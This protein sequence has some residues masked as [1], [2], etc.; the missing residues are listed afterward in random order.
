MRTMNKEKTE[1][2]SEFLKQYARDNNGTSPGLSEIMEYMGMSKATAYRYILEL[3]RQGLVSYSGKNTLE[4]D[5]QRK[6]NCG[7]RKVPLVGQIVC[8]TPD[9]QEE[10]ISEY[11]AI[12]EEWVDGEC[13]LLRAYGD[14]MI[15]IGI[16]KDDLILVKRAE[17]AESGDVVVALTENGNTLKRLFW[18]GNKPR[19]HAE[20]KTYKPKDVD[21]YPESLTIQGIAL[22]VIKNI[23]QK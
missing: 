5:L 2:L 13:F 16:E 17:T 8:G 15:D 19:L 11:L 12:P 22:K 14:S 9:E 6:M 3:E 10:F 7:F 21:I 4:T 1:R 23:R 20:N 18:E